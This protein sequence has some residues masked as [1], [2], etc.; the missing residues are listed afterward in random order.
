MTGRGTGAAADE[1]VRVEVELSTVNRKQL[2]FSIS[3]PRWLQSF[4]SGI[5][6]VLKEG[7]SRGRISGEIRVTWSSDAQA[8]GICVDGALAASYIR[9][10]RTAAGQCGLTDNL[11]ASLLVELPEVIRFERRGADVDAVWPVLEN[12]LREAMAGLL[13]MRRTEGGVLADDLLARL[14]VLLEKVDCIEDYAPQVAE[15]YRKALC[16]RLETLQIGENLL[17]DER[18]LKE[19][20]LFA[21]RSDITEEL[22]RLRSHLAQGMETLR[23]GGVVGRTLDF[24]VQE[25]GREIN[26]IGSKANNGDITKLVISSK[27]ELERIRE[28]VQN[29]E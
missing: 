14:Q 26:T 24:L 18:V 9:A 19:V 16:Q 1:R 20:A 6:S 15:D 7:M 29:L 8:S 5:Q 12:A 3:M 13:N 25:M 4:E 22:V 11:Q 23:G 28:Q 21:D 17:D 2:D 10:I 27:T